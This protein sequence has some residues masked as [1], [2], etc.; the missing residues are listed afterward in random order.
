MDGACSALKCHEVPTSSPLREPSEAIR[1]RAD[2]RPCRAELRA[3]IRDICILFTVDL[4]ILKDST[5]YRLPEWGGITDCLLSGGVSTRVTGVEMIFNSAALVDSMRFVSAIISSLHHDM[6]W[7][8]LS[9]LHVLLRLL[10]C[11]SRVRL[12][13]SVKNCTVI[14]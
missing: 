8:L 13:K 4:F 12:F 5:P 10:L 9:T 2:D 11:M 1:E 14:F 7:H 3:R 6:R